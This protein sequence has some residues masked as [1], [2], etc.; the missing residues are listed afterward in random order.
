MNPKV[1][2]VNTKELQPPKYRGKRLTAI[3]T[4]KVLLKKAKT[5]DIFLILD[6][7]SFVLQTAHLPLKFI[8]K[9]VQ[10][11]FLKFRLFLL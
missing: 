2:N 9:L 1:I 10:S 3:L 11:L 4:G 8:L 7:N 6:F 5:F